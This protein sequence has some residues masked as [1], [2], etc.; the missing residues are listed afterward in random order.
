[1][2]EMQKYG[3]A[4]A[5]EEIIFGAMKVFTAEVVSCAIQRTR[6]T[7]GARL[8]A[9]SRLLHSEISE[10]FE[11]MRANLKP[12]RT[13]EMLDG[14]DVM[15]ADDAGWA[16]V[17]GYNASAKI[18]PDFNTTEEEF[19]DELIRLVEEADCRGLDLMGAAFA[20]MRFNRQRTLYHGGK[21]L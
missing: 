18:G 9:P 7:V 2:G 16:P 4:K 20:K 19:A 11:G 8:L 15:I 5:D 13:Q 6:L 10:A 17:R 1:M 3:L 21:K 12:V 14:S